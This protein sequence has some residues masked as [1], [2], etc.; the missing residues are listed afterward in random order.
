MSFKRI[1]NF[2]TSNPAKL[3]RELSQ[4]EENAAAEFNSVRRDLAPVLSIA[5]FLSTP[6]RSIVSIFPDQQLSIDTTLAPA[7]VVFP[8]IDSR[9]FGRRFV[10]VKRNAGGGSITPRCQDPLVTC[11][12]TVFPIITAPGITIFVCDATGYYQ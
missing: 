6:Q 1:S 10:V 5:A 9:N 8:A 4:L 7:S 2:S 12:G 3:D 11:N